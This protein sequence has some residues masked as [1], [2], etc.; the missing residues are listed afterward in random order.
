MV[1]GWQFI[2]CWE[3]RAAPKLKAAG[4]RVAGDN[5]VRRRGACYELL[6]LERDSRS[7]GRFTIHLGLSH[8]FV[9]SLRDGKLLKPKRASEAVF[10][11][12]LGQAMEGHDV[13]WSYGADEA[14]CN[15][16]LDALSDVVIAVAQAWYDQ[17]TEPGAAYI[18]LKKGEQTRELLWYRTLYAASLG[19]KEEA[20]EW[21]SR[22][23]SPPAHALS[24]KAELEGAAKRAR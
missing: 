12:N 1:E 16:V 19:Q 3:K 7:G 10:A 13:W 15:K 18:L 5:A 20:L 9:R 6:S 11:G 2:K 21:L 17:L 4:Y 8:D 24:L 14:A 23:E 22:I